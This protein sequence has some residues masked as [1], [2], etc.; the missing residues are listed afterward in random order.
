MHPGRRTRRWSWFLGSRR[1]LVRLAR[2]HWSWLRRRIAPA[3]IAERIG[4]PDQT[5]ELSQRVGL[6]PL[7]P[8]L[9]AAIVTARGESSVLVSI[10]HGNES[11]PSGK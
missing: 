10:S 2:R 11:F 6:A 1:R 5:G 9:I 8:A 7:R 4:L 3:L